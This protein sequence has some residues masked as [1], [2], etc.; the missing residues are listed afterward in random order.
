[1]YDYLI[2]FLVGLSV[3]HIIYRFSMFSSSNIEEKLSKILKETSDEKLCCVILKYS[4]NLHVY[5]RL[6][7]KCKHENDISLIF[8]CIKVIK[9][10]AQNVIDTKRDLLSELSNNE[11][12]SFEHKLLQ[13]QNLNIENFL[14]EIEKFENK[15]LTIDNNQD[16]L[17]V[18]L[19]KQM[20]FTISCHL[21]IDL[22]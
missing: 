13:Q 6:L 21:G 14:N 11:K 4:S 10:S 9:S 16:N 1:M 20:K 15:L 5:K 18:T 12:Y 22:E 8:C 2:G 17:G 3:T 7:F 19:I